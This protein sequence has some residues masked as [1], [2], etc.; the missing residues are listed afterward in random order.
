MLAV[1]WEMRG[2]DFAALGF[3]SMAKLMAIDTGWNVGNGLG[4]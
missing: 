4:V 1:F 2:E 3:Y